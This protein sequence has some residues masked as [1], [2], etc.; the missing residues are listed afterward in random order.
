MKSREQEHAEYRIK[1]A[2]KAAEGEVSL[3]QKRIM[4]E[5]LKDNA[6]L[7]GLTQGHLNGIVGLWINRV[8]NNMNKE[9]EPVPERPQ[10]LNMT[11]SSFGQEIISA[12]QNGKSAQ[13]GLDGGA[14]GRSKQTSQAHIDA[15]HQLS[16]KSKK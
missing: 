6:L 3:A 4:N 7:L 2:L 13:F 10:S 1:E 15:L 14:S 11:P 16:G 5:C 9:P 12:M 8:I